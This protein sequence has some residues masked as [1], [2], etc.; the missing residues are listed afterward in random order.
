LNI[1]EPL[2][3]ALETRE[4]NRFPPPTSIKQLED[5]KEEWYKILLETVE[6]LYESIPRRITAVLKKNVVQHHINKEICTTSVV[7]PLFCPTPV[8]TL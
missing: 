7:F 2:W 8:C 3:S 1:T 4:R 5:V 6:T